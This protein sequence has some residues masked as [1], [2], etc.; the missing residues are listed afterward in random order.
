MKDQRK[1]FPILE[2]KMGRNRLLYLDT[3]ATALKPSSVLDA[4][5]S[6]YRDHYGTIHRAIYQLSREATALYNGARSKIASFI[7]AND[8]EIIFTRGTTAALNLVA[9]SFVS[10]FLK[11]GDAILVS[12][13][14]HHSNFVPWQMVA[15]RQGLKFLTIPVNDDGEIS[16]EALESLLKK[17][18]V[19]LVS[20]AHISNTL[21]T[22]HPIKEI[23]KLVHA[24]G[25]TICIDGAQSIPHMRID[26]KELDIDF[27]AFSGHKLYGPTGIG[28]LYGKK[29]HLEK[30]SPIDGGG[31]MIH[32]VSFEKTTYAEPPLR[33]EA[34]SPMSAEV[35]GLGSA[36]DYLLKI[37]LGEI[38][39]HEKVLVDYATKRLSEVKGLKILGN[40]KQKGSLISFTIDGVHPLDLGT[41]LDAKGVALRTG[42]QCSQTTMERFSI[43]TVSRISFGLYNTLDEVDLFIDHLQA[44]IPILR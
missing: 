24:Y 18:K 23:A 2:K 20:L 42:H 34:G 40:A 15:A 14:E 6:F 13:I 30:M 19:K 37:G 22:I 1:E 27:F 21:G 31:D 41:L 5:F 4:M 3:A 38:E 35:I 39:A 28:V 43:E 26:V 17:E 7:G 9:Q 8:A 10:S 29:E 16:L 32:R 33:F 11:E 44:V 36:C 12:E 25:A